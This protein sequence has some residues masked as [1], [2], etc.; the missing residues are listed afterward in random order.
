MKIEQYLKNLRVPE[1]P[2]DVILDTDAYNEI[3]DQFAIAYLLLSKE[4]LNTVGICAAPFLNK[5]STSPADGMEKSYA[6]ILKILQLMGRKDTEAFVFHG[7]ENYLP[8]EETPVVSPAARMMAERARLYSPEKPLYILAIGAITNVASAILLD[9][10]AMTQN[11]VVVFLGG[12][13]LDW[14]DTKEFN[15]RQDIAAARVV[16]ES[17]VPL[18][19]LPCAGVVSEL[20]T[21]GP[22][23]RLWLENANP[24]ADYLYR[25]TVK[26]AESYAAGTAWS[27]CI[28]DVSTVAWLL[29]DRNNMMRAYEIPA[30]VIEYSAHY[31]T[32]RNRHRIGYV[33]TVNRDAIFTDL[34]EKLRRAQ[35]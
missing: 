1:G 24:L 30:P 9:R 17:Q 12:H 26:E 2:V 32:P 31:S 10:E 5:K 33:F 19:M 34:F 16:F 15:M 8:D 4:K 28:W 6:E 7:S 14:P 27:R 11:T 25:N 13:S 29:N 18:V 20:R 21:T 23:L 22:E 3:D 35:G